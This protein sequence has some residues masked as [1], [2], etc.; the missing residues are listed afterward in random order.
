MEVNLCLNSGACREVRGLV[1]RRKMK[2]TSCLLGGEPVAGKSSV[3]ETVCLCKA[4]P[5]T[6]SPGPG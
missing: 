2:E 3:K 6:D 4:R 1:V 5:V